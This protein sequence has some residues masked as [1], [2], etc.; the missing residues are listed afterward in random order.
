MIHVKVG[1]IWT[2]NVPLTND[3]AKYKPRPVLIISVITEFQ[4]YY[5]LTYVIISSTTALKEKYDVIISEKVAKQIGLEK[6]SIIK[7][8]MVYTGGYSSIGE[9]DWE[10]A[11]KL[12]V[13]VFKNLQ[14]VPTP[15]LR[16]VR[17][18]L[19]F[20]TFHLRMNT[21]KGLRALFVF[22]NWMG[23]K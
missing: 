13:W 15:D 1:D 17:L 5:S 7:T 10:P 22:K 3:N 2:F 4:H 16:T 6:R 23:W 19:S 12:I 18:V 14:S 21:K 9:K 8:A 11:W 20:F